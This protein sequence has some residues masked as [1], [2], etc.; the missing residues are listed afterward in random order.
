MSRLGAV[1]T[2]VS[3]GV[4][5][6]GTFVLAHL[7]FCDVDPTECLWNNARGGD[8]GGGDGRAGAPPTLWSRWQKS[9]A[10]ASCCLGVAMFSI[11][12]ERQGQGRGRDGHEKLDAAALRTATSSEAA[13]VEEI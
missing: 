11:G 7:L 1:P 3:R 10:L 8:G 6:A 12:R 9:A 13:V 2:A 5:Q 4:Q